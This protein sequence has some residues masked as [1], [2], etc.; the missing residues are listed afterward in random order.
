MMTLKNI[1]PYIKTSRPLI[2]N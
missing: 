2:N 1:P